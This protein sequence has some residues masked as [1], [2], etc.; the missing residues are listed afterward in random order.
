[1]FP[2]WKQT[3]TGSGTNESDFQMEKFHWLRKKY[4]LNIQSD[5]I[6]KTSWY[7]YCEIRFSTLVMNIK[8]IEQKLAGWGL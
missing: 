6:I 5:L 1:M 4:D 8:N 2:S 3:K 7:P